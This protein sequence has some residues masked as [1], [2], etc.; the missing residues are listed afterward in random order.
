MMALK[1]ERVV[2]AI[3]GTGLHKVWPTGANTFVKTALGASVLAA[4]LNSVIHYDRDSVM[5]DKVPQCRRI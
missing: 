5:I 3:E 2:A 4:V 1:G